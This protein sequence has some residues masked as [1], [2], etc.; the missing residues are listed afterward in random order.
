[1]I[2][3]GL[4]GLVLAAA[5]LL[6]GPRAAWADPAEAATGKDSVIITQRVEGDLHLAAASVSVLSRV[7]GDVNA[8][9][10]TIDVGADARIG[11]DV[12]LVAETLTLGGRLAGGS[13]QGVT[14]VIN[15]RIDGDLDIT[16]A[17]LIIGP[18]AKIGGTITYH[19]DRE[20]EVAAEAKISG[21]LIREGAA[22][23]R[24]AGHGDGGFLGFW[25][26]IV[27]FLAG[28][29]VTAVMPHAVAD[30]RQA[31]LAQPRQ[32]LLGGLA[33][34]VA[35]PLAIAAL[36]I[37]FFGIP[38]AVVLLVLYWLM[39]FAATVA[40]A[41]ILGDAVIGWGGGQATSTA[42]RILA[43]GIGSVLLWLLV[44]VTGGF[45]LV[46]SAIIGTAAIAALAGGVGAVRHIHFRWPQRG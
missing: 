8:T 34:L 31:L 25:P 18:S 12:D 13:V 36:A 46:L 42:V 22:S 23:G 40:A 20:A 38:S 32:A 30:A 16:A 6:A 7:D 1:M 10:T 26:F 19:S 28:A 2:G 5:I 14:V 15:G 27:M 37:T 21:A 35:P 4:R 29:A 17:K 24:G 45:G 44:M 33:V 39:L 43:M 3:F 41:G 11:G 9:A